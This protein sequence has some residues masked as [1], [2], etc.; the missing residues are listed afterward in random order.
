[1]SLQLI[2]GPIHG[3]WGHQVAFVGE[4]VG[5]RDDG[6]AVERRLARGLAVAFC[7]PT[8]AETAAEFAIGYSIAKEAAPLGAAIATRTENTTEESIIL[9]VGEALRCGD[10]AAVGEGRGEG[11]QNTKKRKKP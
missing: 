8:A 4:C 5:V 9:L 11:E 10:V 6:D 3:P 2:A 1:M 7:R